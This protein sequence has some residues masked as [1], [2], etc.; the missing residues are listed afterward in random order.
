[1]ERRLELIHKADIVNNKKGGGYMDFYQ[2]AMQMEAQGRAYYLTL[3]SKTKNDGLKRIFQMLA[4]EELNHHDTFKRM[5]EQA[6][7]SANEVGQINPEKVFHELLV[8]GIDFEQ[9]VDLI[10]AY[11][12]AKDLEDKT[13][14]FYKEKLTQAKRSV[15][16]VVLLKLYYEEK[17]HSMFL[18][19]LIELIADPISTVA[20]AEWDRW[21]V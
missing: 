17:K 13:V 15:D 10:D 19:H 4:D 18:E 8:E 9:E 16:K 6:P 11:Q 20:S 2:V 14:A 1:M 3:M 21:E 12:K 7:V 5:S